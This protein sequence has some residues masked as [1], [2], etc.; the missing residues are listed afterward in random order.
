MGTTYSYYTLE[1]TI[2][3]DEDERRKASSAAPAQSIKLST[4]N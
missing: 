4:N 3:F 1:D 2:T